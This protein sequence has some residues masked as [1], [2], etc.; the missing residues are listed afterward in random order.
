MTAEPAAALVPPVPEAPIP[1]LIDDLMSLP[2]LISPS[3]WVLQAMHVVGIPDPVEFLM[4]HASG[5]WESAATASSA[6][7]HLSE[8][9]SRYADAVEG[10]CRTLDAAWDGNASR[11]AT[12]WFG[13]LLE[14]LRAQ[15]LALTDASE[16]FRK[17][18]FGMKEFNAA[19]VTGCEILLD[20]LIKF[21]IKLAAAAATSETVVGGLFFGIWGAYDLVVVERTWVKIVDMVGKMF[22]LAQ[23]FEGIV[24]GYLGDL[25]GL[26]QVA[27][28][29]GAYEGAG[30]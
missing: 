23:G 7:V 26:T 28:P 6:L 29:A 24:A 12:A 13:T 16:Q 20:L 18:A 22:A 27:L 10:E 14:S 19:I 30:T 3:H 25:Y 9:V 21:A 2:G 8:F 11:A 15:A 5:D 17:V 1:Q 4:E